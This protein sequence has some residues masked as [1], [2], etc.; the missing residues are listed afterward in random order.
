MIT[1]R[2]FSL[3]ILAII[4]VTILS[5]PVFLWN[6]VNKMI[7]KESLSEYFKNIAIGLDQAG[8]SILYNQDKFTVSSWTY[9]RCSKGFKENCIFMKFINSIFGSTHCEDSFKNEIHE[10]Q[11]DGELECQ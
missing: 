10:I 4:V 11:E 6:T 2:N 5:L 8:G 1:L 9:Y 3:M 7:H